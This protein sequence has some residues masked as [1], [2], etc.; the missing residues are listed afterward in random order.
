MSTI[1]TLWSA[2]TN[3][4][5]GIRWMVRFNGS[6]R[7][8]L[9]RTSCSWLSFSTTVLRTLHSGVKSPCSMPAATCW[10]QFV[11]RRFCG[12]VCIIFL[13]LVLHDYLTSSY[14]N[15]FILWYNH[16][17]LEVRKDISTKTLKINQNYHH[18]HQC[19]RPITA[20]KSK[21]E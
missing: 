12:T 5:H 18:R 15:D 14:N 20:C 2:I 8:S 13:L 17:P 4:I 6:I 21:K 1:N 19:Y 7:S 3:I 11:G 16:P 9:S 10:I